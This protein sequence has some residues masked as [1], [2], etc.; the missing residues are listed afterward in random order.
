MEPTLRKAVA[1]LMV[2]YD[3][4]MSHTAD[5]SFVADISFSKRKLSSLK[6]SD[7]IAQFSW[8]RKLPTLSLPAEK[9]PLLNSF[10]LMTVNSFFYFHFLRQSLTM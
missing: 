5:C 9:W 3:L 8:S 10:Y 6:W 2:T 4:V 1:S 7:N